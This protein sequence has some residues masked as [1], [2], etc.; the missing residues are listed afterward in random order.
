MFPAV[1]LWVPRAYLYQARALAFLGL[2]WLLLLS[3]AISAQVQEH[4]NL[5]PAEPRVHA[6]L[7]RQRRFIAARSLGTGTSGARSLDAARQAHLRLKANPLAQAGTTNLAGAWTAVGPAQVASVAFGNVTGRVTSLVLDPADSSG[8]TLY[9]GTTGGGVWKSTNAAGP[10]A[11]VLFSPLTDTLP[12]FNSGAGSSAIASLSIGA[13]GLGGGV[14]LAGTG[15]PNDASDSYYGAGILRSNDGG[16]MW[17]L[18]QQSLDGAAGNHS[19][20]GLS[21]AGFAFS[22]INPATAVAAVSRATE[23][24]LVNAPDSSASAAGLYYSSDAGVTWHMATLLDGGQVVQGPGYAG[25]NPATSV[26]WNPLRQRFYAAVRSHGYYESADGNTWT[27]L[28]H[29]P[30]AGLSTTACPPA[31]A[32]PACPIFRGALAVQSITG[33]LFAL[34]V[35]AGNHDAGL[36]QDVCAAS[37]SACAGSSVLF[38]NIVGSAPLEVGNGSNVVSQADFNLA[39]AAIP[40]ATDTLLYV[41]TIDLYR[42]SLSAGCFFRNTTNA[43][44]GC[45]NRAGVAP[46]QHAIAALPLSAGVLLY[47][48][49]DGG[50]YRSTDGVAETGPV[51]SATDASHFQNLNAGLGSLAEVVSFAQDPAQPP[52]LLAGLGALGSAGT[53]SASSPWAQLSTGE[54]GSVAIDQGSSLNW[55]LSTGAGVNIA[56]CTNGAACTSADF[57]L[58]VGAA[59]TAN[60]LA[61]IHAPFLLDPQLTS[62]LIAGTCRVWRGPASG[63][64]LWSNSNAIS[65]PLG[66]PSATGCSSTFPV[67]RSLAAGGPAIASPGPQNAGSTVLYAGIAGTLDGGNGFGGHLFTTAV[68]N[69]AN[70]TTTWTDAARSPVSNDVAD[71]G[72]FNPGGFDISSVTVDSHDTTGKTVYA[73]VM[74]FAGNG[75]NAPHVYRSTDGGAHWTNISSNLPNA[76]ANSIVVDPNDAN[77]LYVALDTG[78][79]VTSQVSTCAS[80]NCWSIYGT[81]LPNAPVIQLLA[82]P[83]LPTGDGRLGELRAATYGRGIWQIPLITAISPAA[84]AITLAPVSV[85]YSVQQ[86]GSVSANVTVTVT[87]SGNAALAVSS[88]ISTGDFVTTNTC[89]GT[90]INPGQSCAVQVA[91]L[92]TVAGTRTGQLT[93]YGN[94]AGGQATA[95]LSGIATA[96]AAVLLTPSVLAFPSTTVGASSAAQNITISN[97]GGSAVSLTSQAVTGD[98]QIAANTCSATL[99]A[100]VGCT[101]SVVFAPSASGSRSG[102]FSV[103]D[104]AGTQ[105]ASLSGT[106]TSPAT[107]TLNP[108]A[109]SFTAQQLNTSSLLQQLTLTNAGDVALTLIA[110]QVASGDFTI[111]NGCGTSLA[112][113]SSCALSIGFAPKSVGNQTG[114]VA[115]SDVSR[116]QLVSLNGIG[117]APPGVSLSPV[118]GLAFGE[119]GVGLSAPTQIVTLSNNGGAP[120]NLTGFAITGDFYVYTGSN[121]CGTTVGPGAVCT[122]AVGFTPTASGVRNGSITFTSNATTSPQSAALTGIGVDFTFAPNGPTSLSI[123]SGQAAT[124]A[125]LLGSAASLPGSVSFTCAGVPVHATCT[126]N[127]AS[128]TLGGSTVISVTVA[129]GLSSAAI[130]PPV[131]FGLSSP[132]VWFTLLLPCL[133]VLRRRPLPRALACLCVT[134]ALLGAGGC[135]AGRTLPSATGTSPTPAI[136]PSG[137]YTLLVAGSSA[138][139][140]RSVNLTLIVQ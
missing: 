60:D 66:A 54:G 36:Y 34:T 119:T 44:N 96:A 131:P 43:E 111:I 5:Q 88:V 30:G 135:A 116:S 127:P 42:C 74:G 126:V 63:G 121:T 18:V 130:Q 27:R 71:A 47:L 10:P 62:S 35:D 138:G 81:S 73:T 140:V 104:D 33:D 94:V 98:F 90:T 78:V 2:L 4:H 129:T 51:C 37:G 110:A 53:G 134:L 103:V 17:T 123:A 3:L 31:S 64:A 9:A 65:A 84:A 52:T 105:V 56:R 114:S 85:T 106:G 8:N 136:T 115:I 46:A 109:L 67:V 13:L 112:P 21:F 99:A 124:Y 12:V 70:S 45:G 80:S 69:F 91:F 113:H 120:L 61:A 40:S 89:V 83:A 77:T 82:A 122:F 29:Q 76:P 132:A 139:L 23:G 59:Q 26:V 86:V 11:A 107:D 57:T 58:A 125:L 19:F 55:Y 25:S 39:L 20:F 28:A 49:N 14:L 95:A 72:V 15:D 101:V 41:G 68:A 108:L 92:P 16:V 75:R 102:T 118:N 79:Y 93:V 87:N 48:G 7:E 6:R 117:I 22:S 100:G 38:A 24:D 128:S 133:L 1:R 137:M 50:L 97:T 32:S